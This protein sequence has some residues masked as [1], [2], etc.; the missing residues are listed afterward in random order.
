M[1]GAIAWIIPKARS[2]YS[3]LQHAFFY[4]ASADDFEAAI[5]N[6]NLT[7][8]GKHVTWTKSN[9]KLC[10][11]CSSP[12]HKASDCPKRRRSPA[13]RNVQNLYQ[14]FQP[15][16]FANY[17]TP[18]KPTKGAFNPKIT[19]ANVTKNDSHTNL[20]QKPSPKKQEHNNN[21]QQRKH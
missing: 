16:Q 18:S 19:F 17:K 10:A 4:F 3:N 8:D 13:D 15:A 14:R 12:H 20:E 11:I 9:A 5:S 2:N 6:D 1:V 21:N 7:L